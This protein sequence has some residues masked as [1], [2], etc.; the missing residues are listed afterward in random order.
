V[1]LDLNSGQVILASTITAGTIV[2]RGIGKL[3]DES[4]NNIPSGT[5]NGATIVNEL[6]TANQLAEQAWAYTGP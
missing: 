2:A 6:V 4:G 1:S 3:V 5:W